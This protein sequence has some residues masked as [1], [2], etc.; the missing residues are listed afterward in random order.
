MWFKTLDKDTVKYWKYQYISIKF[1]ILSISINIS[2]TSVKSASISIWMIK[3]YFPVFTYW[4]II[5][6]CTQASTCTKKSLRYWFCAFA[7]AMNS[8]LFHGRWVV[9]IKNF[10]LLTAMLSMLIK[11]EKTVLMLTQ[12]KC[13]LSQFFMK[14]KKKE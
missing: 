10:C 6:W 13:F 4:S 1:W 3:Q 7:A 2:R 9:D 8:K 11:D 12:K 14:D 5:H